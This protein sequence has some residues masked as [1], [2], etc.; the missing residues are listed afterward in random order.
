MEEA[1]NQLHTRIQITESLSTPATCKLQPEALHQNHHTF[2][3]A[4]QELEITA[5]GTITQVIPTTN[6]LQ[7]KVRDST[8]VEAFLKEEIL[9]C[10]TRTVEEATPLEAIEAMT[11][12]SIASKTRFPQAKDKDPTMLEEVLNSHNMRNK[13]I[14]D[15]SSHLK[16]RIFL[17]ERMKAMVN[18]LH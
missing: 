6:L 11:K 3:R 17:V 12:T 2:S 9:I 4:T 10:M 8:W 16:V 15:I 14:K 1:K 5:I 7:G 18:N 13:S